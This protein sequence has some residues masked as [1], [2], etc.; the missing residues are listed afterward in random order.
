MEWTSSE[1]RQ[2]TV[3]VSG[4]GDIG[5]K[6]LLPLYQL[7]RNECAD[8]AYL[9]LIKE[10][11]NCGYM[12]K[13]QANDN[14]LSFCDF[15]LRLNSSRKRDNQGSSQTQK[16]SPPLH[17]LN[18]NRDILSQVTVQNLRDQN[19][20]CRVLKSL[21]LSLLLNII[22]NEQLSYRIDQVVFDSLNDIKEIRNKVF[23]PRY[24]FSA[25]NFDEYLTK[26]A[27]SCEILYKQ[28]DP[29]RITSLK[30]QV[31]RYKEQGLDC[32]SGR[33]ILENLRQEIYTK[34]M[35][36]A[37]PTFVH[38]VISDTSKRK[39]IENLPKYII[40][41]WKSC[42]RHP[43]L[44]CGSA[45]MGKSTVLRSLAASAKEMNTFVLVLYLED[46]Y[47][48]PKQKIPPVVTSSS[49]FWD[50]V[51]HCVESLAARTV[52]NYG[53]ETVAA[54][55]REHK[56]NIL[57]IVDWNMKSLGNL[58]KEM[59][60]GTWITAHR[61]VLS[62]TNDWVLLEIQPFTRHH[63]LQLLEKYSGG[64]RG[65]TSDLYEE[66]EYQDLIT[67]P[68]MVQVFFT[69]GSAVN[70][71]TDFDLIAA[72]VDGKFKS[73]GWFWNDKQSDV[74]KLGEVAFAL[75]MGNSNA[76]SEKELNEIGEEVKDVFLCHEHGKTKFRHSSVQDFI[77]A[78]YVFHNPAKACRDWLSSAPS[79]MR[80]FKFVCGMWCNS[81]FWG[82]DSRPSDQ[83]VTYME[84]YLT[85][86]L[87]IKS[88]TKCKENRVIEPMEVEGSKSKMCSSEQ[89]KKKS[90][91]PLR[92]AMSN[93]DFIMALDDVCKQTKVI[94]LLVELLS[95]TPCWIINTEKF[96]DRKLRRLAILLKK[97]KL[98]RDHPVTIKL[99]S[100]LDVRMLIMMWNKLKNIESL[101]NCTKVKFYVAG[102]SCFPYAYQD[103]LRDL[104]R[105]LVSACCPIYI[106]SY[107]GPLLCS[108]TLE[109]LKGFSLK[110]L[111]TIDVT[112]YDVSSLIEILKCDHLPDLKYISVTIEL[113]MEEQLLTSVKPFSVPDHHSLKLRI[114]YF[115][116]IQKFLDMVR[117]PGHVRSLSIYDIYI[118]VEFSLNLMAFEEMENLSLRFQPSDSDQSHAQNR[119]IDEYFHQKSAHE[120]MDIDS[121]TI[122]AG[123]NYTIPRQG[124]MLSI[125]VKI[126][127]P[128]KLERLLLRNMDFYGDSNNNLLLNILKLYRIQKLIILDS[129][130]SLKGVRKV[131]SSHTSD[132]DDIN[133]VTKKLK[134]N[135]LEMD[136]D[137][138]L[139]K[140]PRLS[141]DEREL[142][143]IDKPKG[144][145]IV[146][147]SEIDICTSCSLFPCVCASVELSRK[148]NFDDLA[149]L[150]KDVY[151]YDIVSFNYSSKFVTIRKDVC[152]D[153]RV[154]CALPGLK[155]ET[156]HNLSS[157]QSLFYRFFKTLALAQSISLEQ[158]HLSFQGVLNI[159]DYLKQ[160][161]KSC[162]ERFSLTIISSYHPFDD[163]VIHPFIEMIRMESVFSTFNFL[164]SCENKCLKIKKTFNGKMMYNDRLQNG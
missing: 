57:F 115:D 28:V 6:F 74:L 21:D 156:S 11:R 84:G 7:L 98:D 63:V 42:K 50:Q 3:T 78:L 58:F 53:L 9:I 134:N 8:A 125:T 66:C 90:G 82:E 88:L 29:N 38:P 22:A 5:L 118:T 77:A 104:C 141:V 46:I 12:D 102:D 124:W 109:F 47:R 62:H 23:H 27:T 160:V 164:C 100:T 117:F 146:I 123:K 86:L 103:S 93:W 18:E 96:D 72:F 142:K 147:T 33:S 69:H 19:E 133:F 99:E 81:G 10:F 138:K 121:N 45:G 139:L 36:A 61:E 15:L 87:D 136:S 107:T 140:R 60:C 131:L 1:G 2:G 44:L 32:N 105:T 154:H 41:D 64:R 114:K 162:T 153:L 26:L 122:A 52:R 163:E 128:P 111:D 97:V 161:K 40:D 54:V 127:Q 89:G 37:E 132:G 143:K 25:E 113:T 126:N 24:K 65:S 120:D 110:T 148:E 14:H 108:T 20:K 149:N 92:N 106:T 71:D 101:Q 17:N 130:L 135:Q 56:D 116:N 35:Y 34:Y 119:F 94:N 145:E 158:T 70:F 73:R 91:N 151:L 48:K 30:N 79:F 137:E 43:M 55:I 83:V 16:R 159:V 152:G 31:K 13:L 51:H 85:C 39:V 155:D 80:V 59:Q 67:S 68:D 112:V 4:T 129:Q 150:L 144:K 76:H 157:D 75:K 49:D 95:S